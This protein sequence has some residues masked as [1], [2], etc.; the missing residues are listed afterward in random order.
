[1]FGGQTNRNDCLSGLAR[2]LAVLDL[3]FYV[4]TVHKRDEIKTDF[5]WARF[6]AFTVIGARTEERFHR[7][8]HALGS[9]ESLRLALWNEIQMREFGRSE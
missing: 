8:H 1:M 2:E 3:G 7:F 4:V 5:L 6:V 9:F